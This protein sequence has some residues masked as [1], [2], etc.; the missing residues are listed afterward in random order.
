MLCDL[1]RSGPGA[2]LSWT[3]VKRET[4]REQVRGYGNHGPFGPI[5][6]ISRLRTVTV[7]RPREPNGP[8]YTRRLT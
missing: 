1:S 3:P 8:W 5:K 4:V 2:V 6:A 7:K